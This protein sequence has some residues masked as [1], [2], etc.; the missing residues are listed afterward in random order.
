MKTVTIGGNQYSMSLV[1]L[2]VGRKLKEENPD[3]EKFNDAFVVA[4]LRSGGCTE[5]SQEWLE[6]N[7][8]YFEFNALIVAAYAANN[9]E[10]AMPKSGEGQPPVEAAELTSTTSIQP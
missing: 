5:A 3:P 8:G 4:S 10:L 2:G 9:V 6:E 7:C 1:K